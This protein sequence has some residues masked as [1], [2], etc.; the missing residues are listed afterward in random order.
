MF[1]SSN[2]RKFDRSNNAGDV[3]RAIQ[4]FDHIHVRRIDIARGGGIV[5][6]RDTSQDHRFPELWRNQFRGGNKKLRITQTHDRGLIIPITEYNT[7]QDVDMTID[8]AQDLRAS[9]TP[10]FANLKVDGYVSMNEYF[11]TSDRRKKSN[12]VPC[13]NNVDVGDI[14][15]YKYDMGNKKRVGVI[16]QEVEERMP[17]LVREREDGVKQVQFVDLIFLFIKSMRDRI[18]MLEKKLQ[19]KNKVQ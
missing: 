3:K 17:E 6:E 16:A 13:S 14:E 1:R 19:F 8:L 2:R 11:I 12:I 4:T 9:A 10:R 5:V 18:N 15:I 7:L